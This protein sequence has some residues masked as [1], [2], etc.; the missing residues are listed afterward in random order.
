VFENRVFRRIFEP[1]KDEVA[2][3]RRKLLN[4]EIRELYF[5]PSIIRIMKS[6]RMRRARH[7]P[8]KR[9]SSYVRRLL[10]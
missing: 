3:G 5:S 2:G 9:E 1:D 8:R 6:R 7:V 10:V 4:E